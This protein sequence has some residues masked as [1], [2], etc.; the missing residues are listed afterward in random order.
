MKKIKFILLLIIMIFVYIYIFEN[1]KDTNDVIIYI[2]NEKVILDYESKDNIINLT[3]FTSEIDTI[4]KEQE[5]VNKIMINGEII[6]NKINLGKI[7]INRESKLEIEVKYQNKKTKKFIINLLPST[8]PKYTVKGKSNYEGDYYTSTFSFDYNSGNHYIFKFDI[9]G[10]IIFYKKTN[11][12]AF[13]FQKQENSKGEIRYLYLEATDT[14][15]DGI[16]S[17]LPCELVILD[18]NYNEIKRIKHI[19]SKGN[20]IKLENHG[21]MFID[22]N[23]YILVGYETLK[24]TKDED[25]LYIYNC[26]I[27]EIKEDKVLWEFNTKDYENL[28]DYSTA[29]N[30]DY[31][32][33]YQDYAHFNSMSIDIKDNNLLTSFRNIDA[34]L[35]IDRT[36][37]ELMWILSGKGDQ[38]NLE[39]NQKT[40]KQH[41]VLSVGEN[42]ILLYD[43]G[44][45]KQKS[46]IV[47]YTI[48][49]ENKRLEKF[50]EY[51]LE[52]FAVMMG[53]VRVIDEKNKIYLI[54]YG[55]KDYEKSSIQEINLNT[56]EV[57]FEFTF[58]EIKSIYNVNK[59]K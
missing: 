29:E 6:N 18:E 58:D 44:N 3:S 57:Y 11:M 5:K 1:S 8:F 21:Y 15:F 31:N 45:N 9:E 13:D 42:K 22:D 38:F 59:Y 23:H 10:N 48:S 56:G 30:L 25:N 12:V 51:D 14:T 37:G 27:Q 35:K 39:D 47:E 49:N 28:Y 34:I 55:G 17:L 53:S 33:P 26:I 43:N 4:I 2:G 20:E 24:V 41:S 36:N 16:S 32:N 54:C 7:N 46:R 19:T 40:S 52:L 50:E